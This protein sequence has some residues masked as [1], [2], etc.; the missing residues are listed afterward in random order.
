MS[1]TRPFMEGAE[2]FSGLRNRVLVLT[3]FPWVFS[4]S[5]DSGPCFEQ[6][7]AHARLSAPTVDPQRTL[8]KF[9]K[10]RP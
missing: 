10:I 8:S 2:V 6:S 1:R 7:C 4:F 5:F 9:S 3:H